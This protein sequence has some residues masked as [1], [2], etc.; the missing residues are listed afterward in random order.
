MQIPSS[1]RR[2]FAGC[3]LAASV[4]VMATKASIP[5]RLEGLHVRYPRVSVHRNDDGS[6]KRG[7]RNEV[8][9]SNWSGYAV[10]NYSTGQTYTAA[11]A[12][13][14]V[15]KVSYVA[16][17]PV[18]HFY[19]R[20]R[21]PGSEICF[22]P[23]ARWEYS[24]SWVGIGG[25][26]ENVNCTQ[27]DSTLIQLGTEQDASRRGATEYYAWIE[28]L[29]NDPVIISPDYPN[30]ASL[31]C[32]YPVQPG[33]AITAALSCQSNCT[34][35]QTQS[36]LL[37]MTNK[38]QQWTWSTSLTYTSLLLSAVWIQEA[39]AS[40]GGVLP[41]ADYGTLSFAASVNADAA[42]NFPPGLNGGLGVDAILM[43]D[44]YGETSTPS[45][46]Q[47]GADADAFNTCWGNNANA[48][49]PCQAP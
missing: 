4:I 15:P 32:A 13:W 31:S 29:P 12:S 16:P 19:R 23:D 45:V 38:T 3:V 1:Y 33:D 43:V 27:L 42:P 40:L 35:G 24:A 9:T 26:C 6:V 21:R 2:W 37:T 18:C 41:L 7:I 5:T 48:I 17:P 10:A 39:P 49:A 30:C 8:E 28:A 34:S 47:P 20:G 22:T 44:P 14:S 46:A 36:W 11:Q 25:Y